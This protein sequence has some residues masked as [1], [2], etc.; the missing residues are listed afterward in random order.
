MVLIFC[1]KQVNE[2]DFTSS[3]EAAERSDIEPI[4]SQLY[5]WSFGY[6]TSRILS[7]AVPL[8]QEALFLPVADPAAAEAARPEAEEREEAADSRPVISSI[9]NLF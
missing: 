7:E 6:I 3:I 4:T 1:L 9:S 8:L 5:G 2:N